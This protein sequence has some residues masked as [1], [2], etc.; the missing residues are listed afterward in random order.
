MTCCSTVGV[1]G[2]ESTASS[3]AK[4]FRRRR[5]RRTGAVLSSL[6]E[7]GGEGR[8]A[9][10]SLGVEAAVRGALPAQPA[11]GRVLVV[12]SCSV[13]H[14]V[15]M[16]LALA[17]R[18]VAGQPGFGE[19]HRLDPG[20]VRIA[21]LQQS[22]LQEPVDDVGDEPAGD[23]VAMV[24]VVVRPACQATPVY[25]AQ[26]INSKKSGP[27]SFM[28]HRWRRSSRRASWWGRSPWPLELV[29]RV[30]ALLA[31]FVG[32]QRHHDPHPEVD[33]GQGD[34]GHDVGVHSRR[35]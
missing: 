12:W 13:S 8:P 30:H 15:L 31:G 21:Q 26:P 2:F 1:A 34:P 29:P 25:P 20:L 10:G 16:T 23:R 22:V 11:T 4:Q 28:S 5:D 19:R 33:G 3:P 18:P 35:L 9:A 6:G 27:V 7:T 32:L 17:Q 14:R 24:V